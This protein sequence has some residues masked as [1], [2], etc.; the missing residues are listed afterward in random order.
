MTTDQI[1]T[2]SA[3]GLAFVASVIAALV[4]IYNSR[5]RRFAK[6][7][8]WERKVEAYTRII[9]ALSGLV[10]YYEEHYDAA[11]EHREISESRREEIDEHWSNGYI[12]VKRASTVGAFL[13]STDA[14]SALHAFWKAKSEDF[15]PND[16]FSDLDASYA[17]AQKCL[18]AMVKAAKG[19]L[20][21]KW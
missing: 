12:E 21:I 16:W 1:I 18:D 7:R 5:F 11:I 2:L 9:D 10:Y 15:H 8:W 13:I 6:E 3:A 4:S 14:T 17:A 20:G 19:D